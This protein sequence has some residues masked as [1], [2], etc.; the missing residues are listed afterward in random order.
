MIELVDNKLRS[1]E[2]VQQHT[3]LYDDWQNFRISFCS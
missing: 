3:I 2:F 1:L